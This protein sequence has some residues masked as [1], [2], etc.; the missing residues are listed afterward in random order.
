MEGSGGEETA[1]AAGR[2][3]VGEDAAAF[4]M[5]QQSLSSW[6]AFFSLLTGV[7]ALIYVTWIAPG[8]GVGEDFVEYLESFANASSEM[9]MLG[10]LAV[11]AVVH[12]GLA[13]LRPYGTPRA[14]FIR[15]MVRICYVYRLDFSFITVDA[16]LCVLSF[17]V[18]WSR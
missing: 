13:Y 8:I 2:V 14:Y 16:S 9:T 3:T 4:E 10:I 18:Q 7:S 11:F 1:A 17:L 12:S 5:E 6:A 15:L